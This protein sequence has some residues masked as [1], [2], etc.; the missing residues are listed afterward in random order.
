MTNLSDADIEA[1]TS[2]PFDASRGE[3]VHRSGVKVP[4]SARVPEAISRWIYDE[5]LRRR[6]SPSLLTSELLAEAVAA[7]QQAQGSPTRRLVDV[8]ALHRAIDSLAAAA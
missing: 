7:R 3:V 6:I 1:I 2:Q 8:D 4:L 5:A